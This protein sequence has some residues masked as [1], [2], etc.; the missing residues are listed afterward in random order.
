MGTSGQF[1]RSILIALFSWLASI[2]EWSRRI[3]DGS[4]HN[5]LIKELGIAKF[6]H[7]SGGSST[8]VPTPS[9][10]ELTCCFDKKLRGR[11]AC[12]T[13]RSG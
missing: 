6:K 8:H 7:N 12:F 5:D 4:K 11:L 3:T 9:L 13:L 1:G 10:D 2:E